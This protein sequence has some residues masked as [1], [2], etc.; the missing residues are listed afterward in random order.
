MFED[1]VAE[2]IKLLKDLVTSMEMSAEHMEE[3]LVTRFCNPV[4]SN[5]IICHF[6]WLSSSWLQGHSDTYKH[7]LGN[8]LGIQDYAKNWL[9]APTK[10]IDVLGMTIFVEALLKPIGISVNVLY[11]EPMGQKLANWRNIQALQDFDGTQ[12]ALPALSIYLLS[13]PSHYDILYKRP[14]GKASVGT[15]LIPDNGSTEYSPYTSDAITKQAFPYSLFPRSICDGNTATNRTEPAVF[16]KSTFKN[17]H[18]DSVIDST[19][20]VR[21][22]RSQS[23]DRIDP[24]RGKDIE[25]IIARPSSKGLTHSVDLRHTNSQSFDAPRKPFKSDNETHEPKSPVSQMQINMRIPE[26]EDGILRDDFREPANR[27]V[28]SQSSSDTFGAPE[29]GLEDDSTNRRGLSSFEEIPQ[30]VGIAREPIES[31]EPLV[32]LLAMPTPAFMEH[33]ELDNQKDQIAAFKEFIGEK[34]AIHLITEEFAKPSPEQAAQLRNLSR[35][36]SHYRTML[37]DGNAGLRGECPLS[38]LWHHSSLIKL[39]KTDF[40]QRWCS[41]TSKV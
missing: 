30:D 24:S 1:A 19:Q 22:H 34:R 6:R 40:N 29:I 28:P 35:K 21:L 14:S 26:S 10:D 5:A 27:S 31:N 32:L 12:I 36:Y 7:H 4:A 39:I 11:L 18:Y 20:N 23:S 37:D 15:N 8:G 17:S 38:Q 2:T 13:Q 3:I 41:P 33:T 25:K 16:Q 9:E